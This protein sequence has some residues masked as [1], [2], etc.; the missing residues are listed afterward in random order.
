MNSVYLSSINLCVVS[1]TLSV[2]VHTQWS[3]RGIGCRQ[4]VRTTISMTNI[5]ACA[6]QNKF[7][8]FTCE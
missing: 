5:L 3:G 8:H 1:F 2:S 6:S 4:A 7:H